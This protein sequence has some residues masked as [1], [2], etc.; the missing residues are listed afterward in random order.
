VRILYLS[1]DLGVPVLGGKGASVHVRGLVAAFARAGHR[2]VVVTPLLNKSPW[3]EPA[4]LSAP[5]LHL[6]LSADATET[7]ISIKAFEEAIGIESSLPGELRRILWNRES[8]VA[9]KRR[10]EHHPPDFIYER[11]S[12]YATAGVTLAEE[13]DVPLLVELNAPLAEEQSTY[14]ATGL[15]QL[16][17]RAERWALPRADAVL[18]VSA[19]LRE[20]AVSLGVDPRRAHVVPN[21]VDP[22]EFKPGPPDPGVRARWGLGD[23]PVLGYV[24][25]LR[26]WHG[27]GALPLLL[28]RLVGRFEGVRLVI[29]GDGPLRP[30]LERA[31]MDGGLGQSTVFTGMVPHEQVPALIRA[32][33]LAL[34]PYDRFERPFYFSPLKL[35]E[36]MACGVPVVAAD[37][38]QIAEVID[39]DSGL[40]YPPGD[41]DGL[42]SACERLLTDP[43]LRRRQGETA[44]T[45]VHTRHTWD[46]NAARVTD[47]ARSLLEAPRG[48]GGRSEVG[49]V[50]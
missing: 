10:F 18:A 16:A 25:G 19:P 11:A 8:A 12:L 20:Y 30:E 14:R 39:G 36:Y 41:L 35:F 34:A 1:P 46:H 43:G 4:A 6:P 15:G 32:F 3:D 47:L 38:G 13:L 23:G 17:A 49:S 22:T 26:P 2:V 27:V 42:T 29:A 9:L 24:G 44:A 31:I 37:L 5:L 50:G 7:V 28:E 45:K 48:P 21:A 33:D 40:V